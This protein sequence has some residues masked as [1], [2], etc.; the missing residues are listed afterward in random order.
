MDFKLVKHYHK[1]YTEENV[2]LVKVYFL[3]RY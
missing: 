2:K 1:V 3:E